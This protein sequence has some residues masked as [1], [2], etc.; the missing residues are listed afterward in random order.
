LFTQSLLSNGYTC[1][2][3]QSSDLAAIVVRILIVIYAPVVIRVGVPMRWC[4]D[5]VWLFL[6]FVLVEVLWWFTISKCLMFFF[7]GVA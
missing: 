3:L 2:D 6:V 7:F 1:F 4:F 5:L